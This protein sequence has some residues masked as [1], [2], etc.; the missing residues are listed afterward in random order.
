MSG[1]T[2]PYKAYGAA[3]AAI[4]TALVTEGVLDMPWSGIATALVAGLTAFFIP[5]PP[6]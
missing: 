1:T 5:N 4:L 6:K 3:A 2:K